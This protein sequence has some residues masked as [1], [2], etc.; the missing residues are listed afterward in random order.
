VKVESESGEGK[1]E[2]GKWRGESGEGKVR[3]EVAHDGNDEK[4]WK[5]CPKGRGALTGNITGRKRGTLPSKAIQPID[6][7]WD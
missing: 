2:R 7:D 1:V 4:S 5:R 3:V 6:G